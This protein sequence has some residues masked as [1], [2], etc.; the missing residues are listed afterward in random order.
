[1]GWA[2]GPGAGPVRSCGNHIFFKRIFGTVDF[3]SGGFFNLVVSVEPHQTVEVLRVNVII[4]MR[5]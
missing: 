2:H 5:N 3:L 1:M 4:N